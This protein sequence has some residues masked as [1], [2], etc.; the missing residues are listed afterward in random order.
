[1][2]TEISIVFWALAFGVLIVRA[3]SDLTFGYWAG[4]A[5][6]EAVSNI[7]TDPILRRAGLYA[8]TM[9]FVIGTELRA[10][11]VLAETGAAILFRVFL[12]SIGFG[13][14]GVGS[15]AIISLANPDPKFLDYLDRIGK[16]LGWLPCIVSLAIGSADL[17]RN[18]AGSMGL[19][20][21]Y[22]T[23]VFFG[24]S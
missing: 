17:P 18:E 14:V 16:I 9:L 13:V 1:M 22:A 5:V 6:I 2:I 8:S 23:M 7:P 12:I 4:G 20:A 21:L 24:L 11:R 15:C 3:H 19:I 10:V